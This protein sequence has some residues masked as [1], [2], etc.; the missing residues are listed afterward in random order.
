MLSNSRLS[1]FFSTCDVWTRMKWESKDFHRRTPSG[2]LVSVR[3]TISDA[4]GPRAFTVARYNARECLSDI[5]GLRVG[6]LV[7]GLIITI[8]V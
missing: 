5:E 8:V 6:L 7:V 1:S 4:C 3:L 2:V